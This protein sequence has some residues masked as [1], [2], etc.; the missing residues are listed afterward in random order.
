MKNTSAGTGSEI[1]TERREA[2]FS[3]ETPDAA[4]LVS[5]ERQKI[6]GQGIMRARHAQTADKI[7]PITPENEVF[8]FKKP[9]SG[10]YELCYQGSGLVVSMLADKKSSEELLPLEE[11][12]RMSLFDTDGRFYDETVLLDLQEKTRL[13]GREIVKHSAVFLLPGNEELEL[14]IDRIHC[15]AASATATPQAAA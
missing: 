2:L 9:G 13:R 8:F 5:P 1:N 11:R 12:R 4:V 10:V 7:L 14:T 3:L 15:L 6:I